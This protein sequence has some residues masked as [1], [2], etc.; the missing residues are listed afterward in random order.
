[1]DG[2]G[3]AGLAAWLIDL[4]AAA[5]AGVA[6]AACLVLL[7]KP[8]SA[9][10]GGAGALLLC[11]SALQC[12]R[13]EAGRYRLPTLQL[14]AWDDVFAED[15]LELTNR[16]EET[17]VIRMFPMT[18]IPTAGELQRRIDAH[19]GGQLLHDDEN[20]VLLSPDASAAL[21]NA[22]AELKRSLG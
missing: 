20:V 19:L 10:P 21:R 3:S 13:P 12:V 17:G 5:I 6:V 9:L 15:E 14:P 1:M 7:G 8:L 11:F 4:A 22:L 16:A 18:P 2:E